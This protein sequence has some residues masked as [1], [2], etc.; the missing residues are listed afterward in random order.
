MCL[1]FNRT[2]S[3]A[4]T[5]LLIGYSTLRRFLQLMG[6]Q[7]VR[8]IGGVEH[9]MELL[10]TFFVSVKF[11]FTQTRLSG[12]RFWSQMTL[13]VQVWGRSGNLAK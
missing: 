9:R 3:N 6:S 13:R 10:P 11:G 2:Q 8:F 12:I 4:I 1:S 7:T 5:G